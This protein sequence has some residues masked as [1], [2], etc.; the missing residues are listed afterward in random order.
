VNLAVAARMFTAIADAVN[1]ADPN[2]KSGARVLQI[3]V[4]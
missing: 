2:V 4:D 1:S 3:I